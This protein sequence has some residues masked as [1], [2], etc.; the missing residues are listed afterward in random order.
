MRIWVGILIGVGATLAYQD[1]TVVEYFR[2]NINE[3]ATWAVEETT[4]AWPCWV[5][6]VSH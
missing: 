3:L 1:P 4:C 6:V 2:S 5:T